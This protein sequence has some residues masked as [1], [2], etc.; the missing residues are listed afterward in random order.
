MSWL[1]TKNSA[2]SAAGAY[3]FHDDHFAEFEE[4][5]AQIRQ[6]P[7]PAKILM[8]IG[9]GH[10]AAGDAAVAAGLLA[11]GGVR[12][13]L[14][15]HGGFA[16]SALER[17]AVFLGWEH[18]RSLP[19]PHGTDVIILISHLVK[20]FRQGDTHAQLALDADLR[21][22]VDFVKRVLHD[23]GD[24]WLLTLECSDKFRAAGFIP[25]LITE[26][27]FAVRTAS[28]KP[29]NR[30]PERGFP[31]WPKSFVSAHFPAPSKLVRLE[32]EKV[33]AKET[34]EL[35]LGFGSIDFP[36]IDL[37]TFSKRV[38]D[39]SGFSKFESYLLASDL[40]ELFESLENRRREV[41]RANA[42]NLEIIGWSEWD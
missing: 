15:H 10:G 6:L 24:V 42:D 31:R 35:D 29:E 2:P 5:L 21:I 40:D 39:D 30:T 34:V 4:G 36:A 14:D 28:C 23:G 16:T 9:A 26:E 20:Q 37:P 11:A 25:G 27:G 1:I 19:V 33:L 32:N 7:P 17:G 38:A 8:D 3:G 41:A 22:L 13:A 18:L 12:F